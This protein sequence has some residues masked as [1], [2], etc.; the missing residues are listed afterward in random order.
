[1]YS[2]LAT[3]AA[4]EPLVVPDT[5]PQP[6]AVLHYR[7]EVQPSSVPTTYYILGTV[8]VSA[9]SCQDVA[10]LIRAVKPQVGAPRCV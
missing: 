2:R 5:L 9:E 10:T 4:P 3:M 7:S 1:M 8:H 6:L